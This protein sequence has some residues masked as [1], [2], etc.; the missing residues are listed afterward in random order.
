MT[1]RILNPLSRR[2]FSY[3][4]NVHFTS[5]LISIRLN[6][7]QFES[8]GLPMKKAAVRSPKIKTNYFSLVSIV[9][10]LSMFMLLGTLVV[11]KLNR[12]SFDSRSD[13]SG[14]VG[15]YTVPALAGN[16]LI[17]NP[18]FTDSNCQPTL[19]PWVSEPNLANHQWTASNK[20]SNPSPAG[21]C[22]TANRVSV[23]EDDGLGATVQP[24]QDIRL[25]QVVA[26]NPANKYLSFDMYYVLHTL[27]KGMVTV[28]G[29][30]STTG[31]WTKV[32][33]PFDYNTQTYVVPPAGQSQSWIWKCYSEHYA[34]CAS[35]PKL[36]VSTNLSV[37]YPYYKIELL[38]N[39][40]PV[41]GGFKSTGIQ[42]T[43]T[44][45]S[46]NPPPLPVP[47]VSPSAT[48]T[49]KPTISPKPTGTPA[50]MP[51]NARRTRP[52][53][54]PSPSATPRTR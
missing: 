8:L 32:W 44:G 48:S 45:S 40:P 36:P 27:N 50:I 13:A 15:T 18:W 19:A 52:T 46:T 34:E 35:S 6:L 29:G 33:V 26:A 39:L 31:P 11:A 24:N 7:V 41:T 28:Y 10:S 14:I 53:P 25:S 47:S 42:F 9:I 16:N 43:A 21:G 51:P 2:V 30:P 4:S 5:Q 3:L 20:P 23:G 38:T 37:G 49:P 17:Q 12:S 22:V 54:K 1:I